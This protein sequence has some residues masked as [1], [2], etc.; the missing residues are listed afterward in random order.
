MI[1]FVCY[2]QRD[3]GDMGLPGN[4]GNTVAATGKNWSI[5]PF[6]GNEKNAPS[7]Q[8]DAQSVAKA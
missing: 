3:M 6:L 1:D 8:A 4:A 7:Q 5:F 2:G